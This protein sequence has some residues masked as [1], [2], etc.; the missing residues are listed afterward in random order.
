MEM[1]AVLDHCEDVD[2]EKEENIDKMKEDFLFNL[3]FFFF[4][5]VN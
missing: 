4:L 3:I 2:E 5:R 1:L